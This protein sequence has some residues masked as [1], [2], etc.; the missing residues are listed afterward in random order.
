MKN[1]T[2]F[3][4]LPKDSTDCIFITMHSGRVRLTVHGNHA[5]TSL[6]RRPQGPVGFHTIKKILTWNSI[7]C[8]LQIGIVLK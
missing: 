7:S 4:V 8:S 3:A 1:R 2:T 6:Y 5:A